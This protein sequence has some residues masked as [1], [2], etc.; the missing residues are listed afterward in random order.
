[1]PAELTFCGAARTVTGSKHLLDVEGK[2]ILV[3][4]GLFQGGR[5]LRDRNWEAFP[6][7]PT[8]IDAVILTHA[9]TDH[10]G[11]VPALVKQ[12]Y[13]G[14][15]YCTKA[16]HGIARI[17]LPD[18]ARLQEEEARHRNKHRLTRFDPALPLYTEADAFAALK[19]F[20]EVHYFEQTHLPG[21]C[22]ARF[23]PAGHILGSAMVELWLP[24][25]EKIV[26]GG[27]LGRYDAPI[28]RDPAEIDSAD[29]LLLESTYGDRLHG[30]EDPEAV[31]EE[32]LNSAFR[33][34]R[35]VLVP[36]FS[37]GRTQELL[38]FISKLQREGRVQRVPIFIDSPMAVSAT[39]LYDRSFDE[40]DVD[41]KKLSDDGND[42]LEPEYLT[43]VRDRNGSKELNNRPGPMMIIAG[44]GMASGGRI[45]H[46]LK[47]RL[48]DPSTFVL[49]TG[50]Q[51][52]GTLGRNMI[53][54][55]S[56]VRIMGQY[57]QVRAEVRQMTSLSA[58][59]DQGEII[60]WLRGFRTPPKKVYLVHGEPGP[61]EVLAD[62]IR[63]EF[64]IEV[65]IAEHLQTVSIGG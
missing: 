12:G 18:S 21:G 48:G 37:I 49:F 51:G 15:I 10:I 31:L 64:G 27:D 26:F 57:V 53:E 58:H 9:H 43:M 11:M 16:T 52:E 25:G 29:V 50:Y 62:L 44:S 17:S 45:V 14:P 23:V 42:P 7:E 60:R 54:G 3:D 22:I 8:E 32:V 36:S 33:E 38:Y 61:Q 59:A 1:M 13:Q 24:T 65:E 6:F 47:Q 30:D 41:F 34:S 46:H 63:S 40:H 2:K 28:I 55:A 35:V 56:E 19:L 20:K 39:A 4:C 5:E